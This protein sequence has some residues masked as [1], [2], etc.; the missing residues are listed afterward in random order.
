[1]AGEGPD[2]A[3]GL[4][5]T[6]RRGGGAPRPGQSAQPVRRHR[7]HFDDGSHGETGPDPGGDA[8]LFPQPVGGNRPLPPGGA[9]SFPGGLGPRR[10]GGRLGA[11]D[12]PPVERWR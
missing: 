12:S 2:P 4:D 9:E 1:M 7:S 5:R 8:Q 11:V 3:D 6:A 10:S